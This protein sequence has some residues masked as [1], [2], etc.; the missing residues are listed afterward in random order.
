M[1][2]AT[3]AEW[4]EC[5]DYLEVRGNSVQRTL[6]SGRSGRFSYPSS[7]APNSR[8]SP[9]PHMGSP[10]RSHARCGAGAV[11]RPA[12]PLEGRL[13]SGPGRRTGWAQT[14]ATGKLL[15]GLPWVCRRGRL[16]KLGQWP[17]AV[18]HRLGCPANLDAWK[19]PLFSETYPPKSAAVPIPIARRLIDAHFHAAI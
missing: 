11:R 12:E 5:R 18:F 19:L 4:S 8:A 10:R 9:D 1:L 13:A 6:S 3:L 16:A 7:A 17:Q 15:P 2:L 14:F